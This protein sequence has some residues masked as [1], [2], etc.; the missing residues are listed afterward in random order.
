MRLSSGC[1]TDPKVTIPVADWKHVGLW[2][3]FPAGWPFMSNHTECVNNP[4]GAIR[5][6]QFYSPCFS[7]TLGI[8]AMCCLRIASGVVVG[9][10]GQLGIVQLTIASLLVPVWCF[11]FLWKARHSYC[12]A[13]WSLACIL[14]YS[15]NPWSLLLTALPNCSRW[16]WTDTSARASMNSQV[17]LVE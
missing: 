4:S 1:G 11:S 16:G 12:A 15:H 2:L 8:R 17:L 5:H 14:V 9:Q 7:W 6:Q 10:P 13:L 3:F